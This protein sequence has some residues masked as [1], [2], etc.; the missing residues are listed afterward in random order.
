VN[1]AWERYVHQVKH[2]GAEAILGLLRP[3]CEEMEFAKVEEA[4]GYALSEEAKELYR[5]HDGQE[6]SQREPVILI[7]NHFF[8]YGH[9]HSLSEIIEWQQC[10][11]SVVE[12][13][14]DLLDFANEASELA[15]GFY[16][17]GWLPFTANGVG[18]HECIDMVPGVEGRLGQ[19]IS[20]AHD[21]DTRLTSAT[22][23]DFIDQQCRLL[24]TGEWQYGE[25]SGFFP[26]S[27]R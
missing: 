17:P 24:V 20:Y 19:I 6:R 22:L 9:W 7:D 14:D 18:D 3:G 12:G 2:V 11:C 13:Q 15:N 23:A 10:L 5:I 1:E 4:T 25:G 8:P 27:E 16:Q 21:D 26:R